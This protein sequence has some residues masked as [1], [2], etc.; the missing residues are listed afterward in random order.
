VIVIELVSVLAGV[1]E[2]LLYHRKR[3]ARDRPRE[4]AGGGQLDE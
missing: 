4:A 2:L 3:K 1:L